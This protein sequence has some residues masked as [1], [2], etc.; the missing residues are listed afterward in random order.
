MKT[1]EMNRSI[2]CNCS[3]A[4]LIDYEH[5]GSS[6]NAVDENH[7]RTIVSVGS[8][9]QFLNQGEIF[10]QKLAESL[11]SCKYTSKS[12]SHILSLR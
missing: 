6:S 1:D 8:L 5:A 10:Q 3:L 9:E 2:L 7:V 11:R 12:I 4:N